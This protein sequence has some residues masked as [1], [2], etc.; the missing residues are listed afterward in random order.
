M[1]NILKNNYNHT[2][3]QVEK[4]T[5]SATKKK[6]TV[7]YKIICPQIWQTKHHDLW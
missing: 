3:K 4:Q 2:L 7:V 6:M 5:R 1:K